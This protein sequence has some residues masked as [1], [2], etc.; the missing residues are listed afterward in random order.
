MDLFH[1]PNGLPWDEH[2]RAEITLCAARQADHFRTQADRFGEAAAR[3]TV[4]AAELERTFG[5]GRPCRTCNQ[6]GCE[7]H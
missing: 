1:N 2:T 7:G 5:V 4:H 3:C 6:R